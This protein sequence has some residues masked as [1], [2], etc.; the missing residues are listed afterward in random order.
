MELIQDGASPTVRGV[1]KRNKVCT[2]PDR[3]S[4]DQVRIGEENVVIVKSSYAQGITLMN[5]MSILENANAS[6]NEIKK[7][8]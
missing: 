2:G 1:L 3:Y 7:S 6:L 5:L 4:T 8:K